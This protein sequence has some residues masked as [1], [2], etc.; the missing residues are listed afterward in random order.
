[1]P[2]MRR[3]E[4]IGRSLR[5]P[6]DITNSRES[7]KRRNGIACLNPLPST[8]ATW[9]LGCSVNRVVISSATN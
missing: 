7:P 4:A 6:P 2:A 8:F 1:M 5:Q 3:D 9:N